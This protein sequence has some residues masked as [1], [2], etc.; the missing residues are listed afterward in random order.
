MLMLRALDEA[1]D[2]WERGI[3]T[4]GFPLK[5][6]YWHVGDIYTSVRSHLSDYLNNEGFQKTRCESRWANHPAV[7]GIGLDRACRMSFKGMSEFTP[8]N[9]GYH[10]SIHAHLKTA[11]NGYKPTPPFPAYRGIDVLPLFW[12][13]PEGHID[14]HA[15]ALASTYAAPELDHS[16]VDDNDNDDVEEAENSRR[17]L[18]KAATEPL[19]VVHRV[20]ADSEPW[21]RELVISNKVIPGQGWVAATSATGYCD[22]SPMSFDCKRPVNYNC[23]LS[24]HN[25]ERGT[26]Q[27]DS[28]SGWLVVDIPDVKEGL[29]FAKLQVST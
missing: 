7:K 18:R 29:I 11:P 9:R 23:L 3:K 21:K 27:G 24:G 26:L 8:V 5:E 1:L 10:N 17:M 22:G 15:I 4:D 13:V 19:T 16:W 28:L 6:S 14:V 25:D 2:M 20:T 12:K